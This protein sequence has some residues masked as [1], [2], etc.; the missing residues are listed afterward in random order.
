MN[1]RKGPNS[2]LPGVLMV[3]EKPSIA[4]IITE[5]LSG[6]QYRQ[7]KGASRACQTYEFTGYFAPAKA[8]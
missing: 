8:K 4:K 5:H 6:G 7:R 2:N 3:A 1:V